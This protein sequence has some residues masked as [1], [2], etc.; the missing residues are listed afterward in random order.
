VNQHYPMTWEQAVNHVRA[1]PR[2]AGFVKDFFFDDPLTA[3]CDR[4]WRSTEWEAVRGIVGPGLGRKALDVGAGRGIASYALAMDGWDVTALEPNPSTIVGA[5]AIEAM[6]NVPQSKITVVQTWGEQLPFADCQFDLV[7]AR[8]VLHHARDLGSLCREMARVLKPAGLA[9]A[10]REHVITRPEDL[11]AFLD[12]HPLQRY[13]GG[14]HAYLL[15]EY[16]TSIGNA[17]LRIISVLNPLETDINLYP[18]TRQALKSR[19]ATKWG[20]PSPRWIPDWL[21]RL[22]GCFMN[23]PG[24]PYSFICR[25]P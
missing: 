8:Q 19:I 16:L 23:D 15:D 21:L 22:K 9:V 18:L 4:Y 17:G 10:I 7:F 20:L 2:Q 1:D 3:A 5:G 14:E 11:Q 6:A 12:R 13:Y 25:K 24:R